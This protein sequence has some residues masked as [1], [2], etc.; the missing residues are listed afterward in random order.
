VKLE[1]GIS[2]T[3]VLFAA[4]TVTIF[5]LAV[6]PETTWA[7]KSGSQRRVPYVLSPSRTNLDRPPARSSGPLRSAA[8]VD[9]TI[10]GSWDFEGCDPQGW[11]SVD[12]T[13]QDLYFHVDD[14]A[15]L[16]GGDFGRLVALEGNQSLWCGLRPDTLD[17][18]LCSYV[19]LPGYGNLWDQYF[20]TASCL[21]VSG[22]VSIDFLIAWDTETSYDRVT[23]QYDHCDN[24]WIPIDLPPPYY[25]WF[26]G[27]GRDSISLVIP[28]GSHAGSLRARFRFR[29]DIVWSDEDGQLN[30]DGAFLLDSL[31]V[32]DAGGIVLPTEL[33]E[34]EAV[35]DQQVASGNWVASPVEP[36]GNFAALQTGAG[37]FDR[38]PCMDDLTCLWTFFS[39]STA[40][41]SCGGYM[42]VTVV[43][44]ENTRG[45]FLLNEIWS[46]W[47]ANAGSGST[48]EL[49]FLVYDD[50]PLDPLVFYMWHVRSM[51]AG[52]CPSQ[53]EDDDYLFQSNFRNW[54]DRVFEISPH[55]DPAATSLQVALA[56]VDMCETFCGFY[57]SGQCHTPAPYFDDVVLRRIDS[58]GPRWSVRDVDL[59][60]D[61]FAGDGT[62]TGT[63]RADAAFDLEQLTT[64][65]H[66]GDSVA[67]TVNNPEG[68]I[69]PDPY[70]G[71]GSAVYAVVSVRPQGQAAKSGTALTSDPVRWPV[72]HSNTYAGN[73]WYWVRMDTAFYN[74]DPSNPAP[75]E[76][77]VDLNDNLFTPGD[78]I[79]Y[80]F[81]AEGNGGEVTYY[82]RF[83]ETTD[84]LGYAL[85]NAM[86]FT[87]LPTQN[88][89]VSYPVSYG[90]GTTPILYVDGDDGYGAEPYFDAAFDALG[91]S[92]MVD[93]YDILSPTSRNGNRPGSRVV[94]VAGQ[95]I[96]AYRKIIWSTGDRAVTIGN[97]DAGYW[98]PPFSKSP[99]AAMLLEFL[100]A[101]PG[102]GGVYFT[103][104][105]IAETFEFSTGA[106]GQLHE[107]YIVHS[108]VTGDHAASYAISPKVV[109]VDGGIFDHVLRDS[110]VA[111]GGSVCQI[112]DFDVIRP[113]LSAVA[114]MVYEGSPDPSLEA[115]SISQFTVNPESVLVGVVLEGFS[116]H[117]ARDE[118]SDGQPAGTGH[119]LGDVIGALGQGVM[120]AAQSSPLRY[121][122]SQN[123]PNPFNP[124]TSIEFTLKERARVTLRVYN[125]AGQLVATLVDGE[126]AP[127]VTYRAE[128][129]GRNRS[130]NRVASGVYFYRLRTAGHT[131]TRKMVL[132]K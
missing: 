61:N 88:A 79:F 42:G 104:D 82:S 118:R 24:N 33:F 114:E 65:V 9:T 130:G 94:D 117:D 96:P 91:I 116:Y 30:T 74:G 7:R 78:T 127:G 40:D 26:E 113:Q 3:T 27:T 124:T 77:C 112:A 75:D 55:V 81:A 20:T 103:G 131:I 68:V 25:Q 38:D 57:G 128:W 99:D 106:L 98:S 115:A 125:V 60:Q 89:N 92:R 34:T 46:P 101:L 120:T 17:P 129:D 51:G 11:T 105:D 5:S 132:L 110:L 53:W 107:T 8:A 126:R 83:I 122:M 54:L 47:V 102:P 36:Y 69:V 108:L 48:Y 31:T 19:K 97:G 41:F 6:S 12:L 43:P 37:L 119:H 13:A 2:K 86:E 14:F 18:E 29:S 45:Q 123:Y 71:M 85:D 39:G 63:V 90:G 59:F 21:S 23:L 4:L 80:A 76:F 100:D 56:V 35:G 1:R 72:V 87:C 121:S 44:Y 84:D 15:G 70:S 67:V 50:L 93:R 73:T 49:E 52:G 64:T 58:N 32:T 62:T 111:Y 95:L 28:A 22:D 10:L 16:G 109:A 66:P